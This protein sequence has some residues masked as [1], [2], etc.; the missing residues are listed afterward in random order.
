LSD[1]SVKFAEEKLH[2]KEIENKP[3]ENKPLD[4]Y[5]FNPN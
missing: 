2:M 4:F 3:I 5:P 1:I